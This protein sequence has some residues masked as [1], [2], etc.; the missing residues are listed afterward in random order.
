MTMFA[1]AFM[2]LVRLIV[3]WVLIV[4][5]PFAFVLNV[6][7]KTEKFAQ[8]WWQEFGDNLLSG[9]ILVF[10]IWL[11]LVTVGG[12]DV[13]KEIQA[14]N[15]APQETGNATTQAA[16]SG[17]SAIMEWEN[18]ASFAIAM[19]MMLVG[20]KVSQ[21]FSAYGGQFIGKAT[22]FAKKT[23]MIASGV[24]TGMWLYGAGK[25][26]A[27]VV[28]KVGATVLGLDTA[29]NLF[30]RH[31]VEG[32]KAWAFD[33]GYRVKTRKAKKGEINPDTGETIKKDGEQI[34]VYDEKTG[35]PVFE[36]KQRG[37]IQRLVNWRLAA[38]VAS[39]KKLKRVEVFAKTRAELMDK[40][41]SARPS[42]FL[43]HKDENI[44]ALDRVETGMLEGE[45]ARSEAKTK[46]YNAL[47]REIVLSTPR[48]KSK[49][50]GIREEKSRGTMFEQEAQHLVAAETTEER[51]K[52][53]RAGAKAGYAGEKNNKNHICSF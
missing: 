11:S 50:W 49:G 7:P 48:W 16:Q 13:A 12:G 2:L 4:M 22:D 23:A 28:G 40:R 35:Q 41:T 42:Y 21:Q 32:T 6:I 51:L 10:F 9:P 36:R 26:G 18:M 52:A 39:A 34:R 31:V 27:A 8:Q 3:L 1:V 29:K 30:K 24:A 19:G 15:V 53:G 37:A 47:G 33:S 14:R 38:S 43:M 17:I 44:D 46:Q 25:K 5:S 45:K 20:V